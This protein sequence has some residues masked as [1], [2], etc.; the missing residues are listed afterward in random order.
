MNLKKI[1][2][3]LFIVCCFHAMAGQV[4]LSSHHLDL[5]RP[6][7]YQE[8][9][10]AAEAKNRALVVY[11]ADKNTVTA[12]R[13]TRALFYKDSLA[14]PRPTGDYTFMAGYSYAGNG[15][16][17]VYWASEDYKKILAVQYDFDTRN[18][19]DY[20]FE[21]PFNNELILASFSQDNAFY[22]VT[23]HHTADKLKLYIFN[24]DKYVA[25]TIDFSAYPFTDANNAKTTLNSLLLRYPLQKIEGT[26]F[27]ALPGTGSKLKLYVAQGSIVLT[28]D[29]NPAFTQ[30]FTITTAT[31]ALS[32]KTVPQP[33]L[34]GTAKTN[35][36]YHREKLYQLAVNDEELALCATE[37]ATG[38]VLQTYT[39]TTNDTIAFKNSPLL[40][41]TGSQRGSEIK[42]T[43]RFLRRAATGNAALSVYRTPND[44]MVIAGAIRN[45]VPA[46]EA[47]LGAALTGTIISGDELAD[48]M[49]DPENIQSVYFESL[50]DDNFKH[51][52]LPQQRLAVDYISQF[53]GSNNNISLETVIPF[54]YYYLLGYY[55]ARAKQYILLKFEDDRAY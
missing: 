53:M 3:T 42:N 47:I 36:F 31:W 4:L 41:Q 23:L 48:Y 24:D 43:R 39:A 27:N 49:P 32:Q 40:L 30:L 10:A 1:R 25:R 52:A 12:L 55:D 17:Q 22:I 38:I 46:G 45:I 2:F 6:R 34:H 7:E 54:D 35:S 51:K 50:F 26:G 16:P 8:I 28:L 37:P 15:S 20:S 21:M 5:K 19:T 11:A 44:L 9:L 33:P 14:A 18:V 13:Y 29:N